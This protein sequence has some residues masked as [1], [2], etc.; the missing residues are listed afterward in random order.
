MS[1][2]GDYHTSYI[3]L[4]FY[5]IRHIKVFDENFESNTWYVRYESLSVETIVWSQSQTL[6]QEYA[7]NKC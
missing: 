3:E 2:L 5:S 6:D 4:Q 1:K 7:W